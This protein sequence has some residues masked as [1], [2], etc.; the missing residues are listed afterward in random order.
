M[1][2]PIIEL[3][4]QPIPADER[5]SES[6]LYDDSCVNYFTDY[7]G[8][9][10]TEAERKEYIK[11]WALPKLLEGVAM[12]DVTHE[13]IIFLDADTIRA[14]IDKKMLEI[15]AMI[16]NKILKGERFRPN[17]LGY[18]ADYWRDYMELF[19]YE[20]CCHTSGNLVSDAVWYAGKT[21]YIGAI[22]DAHI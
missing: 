5:M 1:H 16:Q 18:E 2:F 19:H 13:A 14:S 6:E 7:F 21:L 4:D 17:D 22:F 3:K 9:E 10:Y 12:V 8:E 20:G 15:A 11:S